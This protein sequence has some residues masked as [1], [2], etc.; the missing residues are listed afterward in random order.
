MR[1]VLYILGQLDD[2]DIGWM[3]RHGRKRRLETGSVLITEGVPVDDLFIVLDGEFD[4]LVDK[5][6]KVAALGAGE[7]IGEMSFVDSQPPS[8]T[9]RAGR[10]SMVLA[11][12]KAEMAE[13]LRADTGFGAR[14]YRAL[15]IFLSDR[16]R[17]TQTRPKM[18]DDGNLAQDTALEDEID[19]TVLDSVSKAGENFNRLLRMLATP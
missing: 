19:V 13:R 3:A 16:L 17:K 9:V 12:A 1:K 10:P 15:A 2:H 4:V 14:F 8:A 5:V 11:V 18:G 7:I 6:G